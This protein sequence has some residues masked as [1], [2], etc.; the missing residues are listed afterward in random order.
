M[1]SESLDDYRRRLLDRYLDQVGEYRSHLSGLA[2]SAV[3][4][5]IKPGEW[6][7]HQLLFHVRAV[8]QQAYGPRLE[9]ILREAHPAL[10]DFHESEWM[11]ANYDPD[12]T[13]SA[14]LD[15]WESVRGDNADLLRGAPPEAWSRTGRQA[16][17]GERTLQWWVERAIAHTDDHWR[18]LLGE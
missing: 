12:E 1:T 2:P 10:E 11:A 6:S 7:P 14:I 5:E 16:Y 17:W 9:R 18:Q 15:T 4:T 13:A 8:D 3:R